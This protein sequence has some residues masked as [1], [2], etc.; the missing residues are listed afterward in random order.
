[1]LRFSYDGSEVKQYYSTN[2]NHYAGLLGNYAGRPYAIAGTVTNKVE[3]VLNLNGEEK[4]WLINPFPF[5][6]KLEYS[7]T[8]T[9]G[10]TLM[11]FGMFKTLISYR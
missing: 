9:I 3:T 2:E 4:F 10:D 11:T 5:G 7:S 8:V 1:M 6:I